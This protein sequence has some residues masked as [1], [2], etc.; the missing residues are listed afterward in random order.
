MILEIA[1]TLECSSLP[2]SVNLVRKAEEGRSRLPSHVCDFAG[3]EAGD[4]PPRYDSR[5]SG[6]QC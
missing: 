1:G 3:Q 5:L 4:K 2:I 6:G